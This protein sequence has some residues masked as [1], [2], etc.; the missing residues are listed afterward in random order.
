MF[1]IALAS[2]S[3]VAGSQADWLYGYEIPKVVTDKTVYLT[4]ETV[5]INVTCY[6]PMQFTSGKQCYFVVED[7]LDNT[8]Y[9]MSR[10]YYWVQVLTSLSPP[11]TFSFTWDQKNDTGVQVPA[12][13][14]EIWGYEAGYRMSDPPIAGNSTTITIVDDTT[15]TESFE[16][17]YLYLVPGWNL[18]SLPLMASNYTASSLG[19]P[20]GS[21]VAALNSTTRSYEVFVVGISPPSMSFP[22][23]DFRGY[24]IY[25][26]SASTV[27][28][29]GVSVTS[30]TTFEWKVPAGGGWVLAGF[31][32]DGSFPHYARDIPGWT[33]YP[34]AVKM[35]VRFSSPGYIAW[36]S[37]VPTMNSFPLFPGEGYGIFLSESVT[38]TY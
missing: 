12:G 2:L 4:G 16:M 23:V 24:F 15:P 20:M 9:N 14:Y 36:V 18:V 17:G 32:D 38:V 35:V 13:S 1:V 11:K 37:S 28:I 5:K 8:V 27:P 10:H 7:S 34:S 33:D 25:A 19:L 26:P 31:P 30:A 22:L 21:V 3:I 6:I 29:F